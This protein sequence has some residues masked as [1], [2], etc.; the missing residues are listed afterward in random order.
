MVSAVDEMFTPKKVG[1]WGGR[2][3]MTSEELA[4]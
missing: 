3:K 4:E 1:G 2:V